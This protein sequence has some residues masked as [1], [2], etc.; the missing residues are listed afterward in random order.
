MYNQAFYHI[1]IILTYLFIFIIYKINLNMYTVNTKIIT[2]SLVANLLG[3]SFSYILNAIT[4]NEEDLI[5]NQEKKLDFHTKRKIIIYLIFSVFAI[6]ILYSFIYIIKKDIS[7]FFF[8]SILLLFSL[9]YSYPKKFKLKRRLL[10]KN[11]A[12]AM[13]WYFSMFIAFFLSTE[14][15][16]SIFLLK[17][18]SPVFILIVIFGIIWDL[19]DIKGDSQLKIKTLPVIFGFNKIKISLIT[20]L[21]VYFIYTQS[22]PNKL[23][24]LMTL[25]F[26][27]NIKM[28]HGKKIYFYF[29]LAVNTFLFTLILIKYLN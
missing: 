15:I 13:C 9:L 11:I 20:L 19:P 6:F 24:S 16:D 25:I 27:I 5:N 29:L 22:I 1:N 4:D 10:V 28:H 26:L 2:L 23:I 21:S 18:F 7:V 14:A 12:P 17:I 8:P 3:I